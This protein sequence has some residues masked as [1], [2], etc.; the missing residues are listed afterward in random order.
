MTVITWCSARPEAS[1]SRTN[2]RDEVC[3][4]EVARASTTRS[5]IAARKRDKQL[6][7]VYW[8]EMINATS[9]NANGT[10]EI[11]R[12]LLSPCHHTFGRT[13]TCADVLS[14]LP[15]QTEFRAWWHSCKRSKRSWQRSWY[16]WWR[17]CKREYGQK[18]L[19]R[20]PPFTL[21]MPQAA[22]PQH[23]GRKGWLQRWQ[24]LRQRHSE[25][26]W[27]DAKPHPRDL[28]RGR[29]TVA[30]DG[31]G[32]DGQWKCVRLWSLDRAAVAWRK[33]TVLHADTR[34]ALHTITGNL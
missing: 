19:P 8:V 12:F 31:P 25:T 11:A 5:R 6:V 33:C 2:R 21:A 27:L 15:S 4:D 18:S 24:D 29:G 28:H 20:C 13:I 16:S 9:N 23:S 17:S 32:F 14:T 7:P 10:P 3:A 22:C 34:A 1:A 30:P 26:G